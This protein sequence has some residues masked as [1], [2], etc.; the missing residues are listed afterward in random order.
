[1]MIVEGLAE[2]LRKSEIVYEPFQLP[3]LFF[4]RC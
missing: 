4:T 2:S 1:M 3:P